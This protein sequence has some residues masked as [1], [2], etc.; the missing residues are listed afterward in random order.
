M[1]VRAPPQ[2]ATHHE[3]GTEEGNPHERVLSGDRPATGARALRYVPAPQDDT[4]E[5]QL[6]ARC[7]SRA[8]SPMSMP[9]VVAM[10][11]IGV[12]M[13]SSGE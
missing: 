4:S 12:L 1:H 11:S 8:R 5:S 7:R 10:C 3:S 9:V 13:R 6:I 2:T